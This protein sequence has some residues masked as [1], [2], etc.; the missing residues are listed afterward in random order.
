MNKLSEGSYSEGY[1]ISS[2]PTTV[3]RCGLFAVF[4]YGVRKVFYTH[5]LFRYG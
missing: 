1:V 4:Y 5:C 3:N 2:A